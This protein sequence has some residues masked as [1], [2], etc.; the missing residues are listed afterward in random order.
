[1]PVQ[2]GHGIP[3]KL[4]VD[5]VRFQSHLQRLANPR[6]VLKEGPPIAVCKPLKILLMPL[7]RHK[8]IASEELVRIQLRNTSPRLVDNEAC[9]LM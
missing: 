2:M 6:H 1:M 5:L 7:Q 9:R 8:S 4:I 3:E